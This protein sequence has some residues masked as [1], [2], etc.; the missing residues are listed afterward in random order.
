MVGLLSFV[1]FDP[2]KLVPPSGGR[3]VEDEAERWGAVDGYPERLRCGSG[4]ERVQAAQSRR[5]SAGPA[6]R[7]RLEACSKEKGITSLT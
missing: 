3:S 6:T 2:G 5:G 1:A 7:R 4:H